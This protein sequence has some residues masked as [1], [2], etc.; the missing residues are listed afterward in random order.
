LQVILTSY[1]TLRVDAASLADLHPH[2]VIFDEAH[3]LKNAKSKQ[4]EA[5]ASLPTKYRYGLSGKLCCGDVAGSDLHQE[6][7]L[8]DFR[9]WGSPSSK[10]SWLDIALVL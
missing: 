4:Y 8:P 9:A 5:A 7:A 2:A 6:G 3:K 1:D 10:P